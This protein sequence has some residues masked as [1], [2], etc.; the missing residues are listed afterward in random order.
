MDYRSVLAVYQIKSLNLEQEN[1]DIHKAL[2]IVNSK[3]SKKNKKVPHQSI[4]DILCQI[5]DDLKSYWI[6]FGFMNTSTSQNFSSMLNRN[7]TVREYKGNHH[8]FSAQETPTVVQTTR[9]SV[10]EPDALLI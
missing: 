8:H 9:N 7:L 4:N 10:D 1:I 6:Q 5:H 3:F 2:Q